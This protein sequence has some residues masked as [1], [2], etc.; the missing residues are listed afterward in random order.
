M[1]AGN[2]DRELEAIKPAYHSLLLL[3]ESRYK[4]NTLFDRDSESLVRIVKFS[5]VMSLLI[6]TKHSRPLNV[7]F[8]CCLYRHP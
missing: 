6:L 1:E 8:G 2:H 7:N 3:N 4:S 5:S